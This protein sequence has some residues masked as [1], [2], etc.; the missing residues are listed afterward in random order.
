V[1]PTGVDLAQAEKAV[2]LV[3]GLEVHPPP[4]DDRAPPEN[5]P[6]ALD[7]AEAHV[8]YGANRDIGQ[9]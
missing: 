7:F 4:V 5:E 2:D 8:R 6:D 3:P 1:R 9:L